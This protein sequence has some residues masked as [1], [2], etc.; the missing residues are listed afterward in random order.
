MRKITMFNFYARLENN[1]QTKKTLNYSTLQKKS[2][3]DTIYV[4]TGKTANCDDFSG[5]GERIN[6]SFVFHESNIRL[7]I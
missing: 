7:S 4:T 2:Y 1:S 5:G 3:C 6:V